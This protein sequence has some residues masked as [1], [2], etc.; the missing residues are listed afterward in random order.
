MGEIK[1]HAS[2]R[3]FPIKE[4][5]EEH[6]RRREQEHHNDLFKGEIASD[7]DCNQGTFSVS[8]IILFG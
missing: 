1:S 2:E 3:F 6:K 4:Q 8:K 7:N 5:T